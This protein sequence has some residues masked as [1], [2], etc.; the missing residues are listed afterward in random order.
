MADNYFELELK[1]EATFQLQ[2]VQIGKYKE[3]NPRNKDHKQVP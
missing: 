2:I 3:I 1:T